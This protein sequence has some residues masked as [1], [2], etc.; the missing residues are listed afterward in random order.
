MDVTSRFVQ[1]QI[2]TIRAPSNLVSIYTGLMGGEKPGFKAM[3]DE[4]IGPGGNLQLNFKT[5]I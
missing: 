2:T 4:Y 3:K 1:V 5:K